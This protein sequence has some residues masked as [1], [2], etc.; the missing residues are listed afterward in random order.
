MSYPGNRGPF[1]EEDPLE[2]IDLN[3]D[4]E[5]EPDSSFPFGTVCQELSRQTSWGNVGAS[6]GGALFRGTAFLFKQLYF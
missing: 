1:E 3:K 5:E 4:Q 2:N 6:V